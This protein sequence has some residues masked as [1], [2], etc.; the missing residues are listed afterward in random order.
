MA[1]KLEDEV[2]TGQLPTEVFFAVVR[3]MASLI[4]ILST[5]YTPYKAIGTDFRFEGIT[6]LVHV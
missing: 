3:T 5:S 1:K 4:V 6:F 2:P